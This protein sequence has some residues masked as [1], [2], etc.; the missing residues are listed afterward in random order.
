MIT[1]KWFRCLGIALSGKTR[2]EQ[3]ARSGAAS[4]KEGMTACDKLR[5]QEIESFSKFE[6]VDNAAT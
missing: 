2:G 3:A 4:A 5:A 1:C 6:E